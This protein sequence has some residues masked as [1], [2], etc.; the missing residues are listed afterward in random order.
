MMPR[1]CSNPGLLKRNGS[2]RAS[3]RRC[4]V[5]ID[6]KIE[7][8]KPVTEW[9]LR[10]AETSIGAAG[11]TADEATLTKVAPEEMRGELPRPARS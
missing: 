10:D 11:Y 4:F 8:F 3:R 5:V 9:A 6:L 1:S 2:A 7:D